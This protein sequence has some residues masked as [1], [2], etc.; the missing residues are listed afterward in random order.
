MQVE[1]HR[2]GRAQTLATDAEV[3]DSF[4]SKAR[5][6]MFR[7]G[8]PDDYAL[9][10]PFDDTDRRSLHM[11]F[12]PFDIDALWLCGGEVK[13]KK[14]L[15]A[16]TGIGFGLADTIVELPAGAADDVDVGDTI[17]LVE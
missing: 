5:G 11:V 9:V 6:L 10:F 8:V 13:K 14:R 17:R 16:W 3:A 1:H 12:V 15:S 7:R 2:N 4:L